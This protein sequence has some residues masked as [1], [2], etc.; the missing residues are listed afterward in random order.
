[1]VVFFDFCS[2]FPHEL[3]GFQTLH[4]AVC[5]R[6]APARRAVDPTISPSSQALWL[7]FLVSMANCDPKNEGAGILGQDPV[8]MMFVELP[9]GRSS[10]FDLV[11]RDL[12]ELCSQLSDCGK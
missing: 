7:R 4:R 12:V 3:E 11:I 10:Q 1:M 6:V 8:L 9:G 5:A 2:L